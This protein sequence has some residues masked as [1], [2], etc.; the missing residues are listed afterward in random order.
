MRLLYP[1]CNAAARHFLLVT[2]CILECNVVARHFLYPE[3][4]AAEMMGIGS[5]ASICRE[6]LY[7]FKRVLHKEDFAL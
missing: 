1:E 2:S 6:D 7:T 5:Q 4:N 3:Y